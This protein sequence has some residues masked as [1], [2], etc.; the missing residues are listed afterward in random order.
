V[1]V[2]RWI[3]K[4]ASDLVL[5]DHAE[6]SLDGALNP[7]ASALWTTLESAYPLPEGM[8][9]F[10]EESLL[11]SSYDIQLAP[12]TT[13]LELRTWLDEGEERVVCEENVRITD[14]T[15]FQDARHLSFRIPPNTLTYAAGDVMNIR[16]ENLP[17]DVENL[18]ELLGY[19]DIADTPLIIT[20]RSSG[21]LV[22]A[23]TQQ[24]QTLRHLF[25]HHFDAFSTPRNSFF[26]WLS[27]FVEDEEHREKLQEF[28]SPAGQDDLQAYCRRM[29]RTTV[30][31]LR[32]F[33]P[34][35]IPIKY[36]P[37][38]FPRL[39]PRSF[40]IASAPTVRPFC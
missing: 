14:P 19:A 7:W 34:F 33:C 36:L 2:F 13:P 15:H 40:S 25:T 28:V 24:P 27:H 12:S 30:E 9:V 31:V 32:D 20:P 10:A 35:S 29:R 39:R 3:P 37:D 38:V 16:P 11:P 1:S 5:I 26:E 17:A 18:L 23:W 4:V 8:T 22:H 6:N 21:M